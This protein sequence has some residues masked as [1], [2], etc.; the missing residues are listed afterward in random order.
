LRAN[1]TVVTLPEWS[2]VFEGDLGTAQWEVNALRTLQKIDDQS[3]KALDALLTAQEQ[4]QLSNPPGPLLGA[5]EYERAETTFSKRVARWRKLGADP[6]QARRQAIEVSVEDFASEFIY[7][8]PKKSR[9]VERYA[10][11]FT[12]KMLEAL[13]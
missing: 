10:A 4:A 7:P 6:E 9:L 2:K 11:E 13:A 1:V 3:Q 8:E 5:N 12:Y